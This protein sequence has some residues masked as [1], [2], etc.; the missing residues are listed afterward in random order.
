MSGFATGPQSNVEPAK[1]EPAKMAPARGAPAR[2][3][4]ARGARTRMARTRAFRAWLA[5]RAAWALARAAA[6]DWRHGLH[7]A[8]AQERARAPLFLPV[9]VVIG[10]LAYFALPCEPP[11]VL[12]PALAA[13]GLAACAV[14]R[15]R[16]VDGLALAPATLATALALGLGAGGLASARAPPLLAVPHGAVVL[17]GRI[18][19][20][21]TL[22]PTRPHRPPARRLTLDR[23]RLANAGGP[24]ARHIRVRLAARDA[25]PLAAGDRV[26][27]R[28]LLFPPWPPA[29]PGGWDQQRDAFFAGLGAGGFALGPV[30]RLRKGRPGAVGLAF[31]R[32]REAIAHAI[33]AID[34]GPAGAIATTLLTGAQG[35]IPLADRDAFRTAGLAHLLAVA[36]LHIGIVMGLAAA[37]ARWL[38]GFSQTLLLRGRVHPTVALAA[39]AA[40]LF[41]LLLTGAHLPILRSFFMAA[42]VTLAVLAGRRAASLRALALAAGAVALALPQEVPGASF[43][44]SFA[45]VLALIAGY[46]AL[47]PVL[48]RLADGPGGARP[49]W[50][51]LALHGVMLALT[52]LFAGTAS[53]PFGLYHFGRLQPWFIPAN[54]LAV[55][56]TAL[57]V[58]PA[59]LA[60][61]VLMALGLQR[62]AFWVMVQGVR[63]ILA[64]ARAVA[65]LPGASLAVPHMPGAGLGVLAAGL[66]WLCLWRTRLRLAGLA[67][68]AL[69]AASP[70]LATPPAIFVAA[71][72]RLAAMRLEDGR[73][74]AFRAPGGSRFTLDAWAQYWGVAMPHALP[75]GPHPRPV[76]AA[77]GLACDPRGCRLRAG[78]LA[79]LVLHGPGQGP[80]ACPGIDVL[81]ALMPARGACAGV[82]MR[83]DRRSLAAS[84]AVAIWPGGRMRTANGVRGAR[85]WLAAGVG[86]DGGSARASVADRADSADPGALPPMATVDG[87]ARGHAH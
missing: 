87:A 54:M 61:L 31:E 34:A 6:P 30:V 70:W 40:G 80:R 20:I 59:G 74:L 44:M 64:L 25:T 5:R 19:A 67:A 81:I 45:A 32:L 75:A 69:G 82:A 55:P 21:E 68:I 72:A 76:P 46:E 7:R 26:E 52:S 17:R 62:P 48:L 66:V 16:G 11:P 13:T 43:Q 38:A 83:L 51:R 24:L 79:V 71:D 86:G 12:A 33:A 77:A 3:A 56:I 65:A 4:P 18:T 9:F 47:R 53:A 73:V 42:L 15:R 60:G 28:A 84:G 23:V 39:L 10:V 85:P 78:G 8:L 14:L 2:G 35:A 63:L 27:L 22:A 58:M 50:R 29:Y 37:L 1:V 41:Y 49:R 36:G 57:W